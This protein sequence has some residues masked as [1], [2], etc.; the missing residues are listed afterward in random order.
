M[1]DQELTASVRLVRDEVAE[2]TVPAP[3]V[4]KAFM[5]AEFKDY[6]RVLGVSPH[7]RWTIR[8]LQ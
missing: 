5:P 6:Y 3:L 4:S 1:P 2:E 8:A 7:M